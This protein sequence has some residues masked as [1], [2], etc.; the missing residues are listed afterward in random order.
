MQHNFQS[1]M[2]LCKI[3]TDFSMICNWPTL[4]V[5]LILKISSGLSILLEEWH[6]LKSGLGDLAYNCNGSDKLNAESFVKN[7]IV[8]HLRVWNAVSNTKLGYQRHHFFIFLRSPHLSPAEKKR[9]FSKKIHSWSFFVIEEFNDWCWICSVF[10][11]PTSHE[12]TLHSIFKH[13]HFF[14][15]GGKNCKNFVTNYGVVE[16]T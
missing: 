3:R 6:L 9:W 2:L 5:P 11:H 13:F 8:I 4:V 1:K 10:N 12:S 15:G 14:R 7:W 16:M